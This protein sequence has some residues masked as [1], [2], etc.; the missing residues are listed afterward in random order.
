MKIL[1]CSTRRYRHNDK[2]TVITGYCVLSHN[3]AYSLTLSFVKNDLYN[4]FQSSVSHLHVTRTDSR[5]SISRFTATCGDS[6]ILIVFMTCFEGRYHSDRYVTQISFRS[7]L[8]STTSAK[9]LFS[10][11]I[12]YV[13]TQAF[14]S[15]L[16]KHLCYFIYYLIL[17]NFKKYTRLCYKIHKKFNLCARKHKFLFMILYVCVNLFYLNISQFVQNLF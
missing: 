14:D 5:Y 3:P 4:V 12:E 1:T 7:F 6:V 10:H 13:L 9:F 15:I 2:I 16:F 11:E 17:F 8:L